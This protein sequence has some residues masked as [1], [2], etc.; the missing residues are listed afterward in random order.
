MIYE[1]AFM[2][3]KLLLL[4]MEVFDLKGVISVPIH[5]L[6]I[7]RPDCYAEKWG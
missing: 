1:L 3:C 7:L 4:A 6:M 5:S 2:K